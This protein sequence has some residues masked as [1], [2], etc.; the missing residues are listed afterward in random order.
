MTIKHFI[1]VFCSLIL[2]S[3]AS[4]IQNKKTTEDS[5]EPKVNQG[6]AVQNTKLKDAPAYYNRAFLKEDKLDDIQ[7]AIADYDKAIIINPKYSEAYFNRAK[8][9]ISKRNKLKDIQGALADY[10]QAIIINPKYS[11][12]Y[13]RRAQLKQNKLND[14]SGAL[15]DYDQMIIINPKNPDIY[16]FR[17]ALKEDK[18]NDFSGALA[19]YD[20]A[21][22]INPKSSEAYYNRA[23][24]KSDKLSDQPGAIKDFR[25]VARLYREQGNNGALLQAIENLRK[26]GATE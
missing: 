14:F 8:L 26:L 18:L 6:S 24:L 25:Q 5:K 23:T 12:V 16:Y 15:A 9:K 10:D 7:G 11:E 20:Q 4:I 13:F 3:C 17:A 19:D 21:I 1:L 2:V 22:I